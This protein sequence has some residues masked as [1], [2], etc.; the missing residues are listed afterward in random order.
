MLS[1]LR[2][3]KGISLCLTVDFFYN[4]RSGQNLPDDI[5]GDIFPYIPL[6][7][8]IHSLMILLIQTLIEQFQELL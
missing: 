2:Y 1:H 6:S 5:S 4:E 3:D 8:S 7:F